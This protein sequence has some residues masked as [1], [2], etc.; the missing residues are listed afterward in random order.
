MKKILKKFISVFAFVTVF[1]GAMPSFKFVPVKTGAE[2]RVAQSVRAIEL[3]LEEKNTD[4]VSALQLQ[5]SRY[6]SMFEEAETD[7]EREKIE[8]LIVAT[9]G[10]IADYTGYVNGET[11]KGRGIEHVVY[12]PAISAIVAYFS[13]NNYNLSA[14]LLSHARMNNEVNSIYHP[15]NGKEVLSSPVYQAICEN[16]LLSG[17][18]NFP[19]EGRVNDMDL[20][21]SIHNFDYA[22]FDNGK[23]VVIK[24]RYDFAY[25]AGFEGLDN[26]SVNLA[27]EAQEA[28]V[29]VPFYNIIDMKATERDISLLG[30]YDTVTRDDLG[31]FHVFDNACD[32]ECNVAGCTA[33]RVAMEH[34]DADEDEK[35]DY[36]GYTE[37]PPS[38]ESDDLVEEPAPKK[39]FEQTVKETLRS[40]KN[41]VKDFLAGC[42]SVLSAPIGGFT[43]LAFGIVTLLKKKK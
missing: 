29:L 10:M 31:E 22:K 13:A 1:L 39:D 4:V 40:A 7:A 26:I 41:Y 11:P 12:T 28:G 20:F 33:T 21:Y 36:C 42:S 43:A 27:Y 16:D 24:D 14:E 30:I 8:N 34:T 25:N 17:S 9:D 38:D 5:R 3:A 2:E 15:V 18:G 23:L 37:N 6:E 19:K 32:G 35:C